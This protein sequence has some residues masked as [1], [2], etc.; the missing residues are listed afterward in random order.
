[1]FAN[2]L[3][4]EIYRISPPLI[5]ER[6]RE[7][8][9][10]VRITREREREGSETNF[11]LFF[12][13]GELASS[14]VDEYSCSYIIT[15]L[16]HCLANPPDSFIVGGKDSD[17]SWKR[18]QRRYYYYH[19]NKYPGIMRGAEMLASG[20]KRVRP[21]LSFFPPDH[22]RYPLKLCLRTRARNSVTIVYITWRK[23]EERFLRDEKL[24]FSK[25]NHVNRSMCKSALILLREIW[26]K[27]RRGT[28]SDKL[29]QRSIKQQ[30][31]KILV[32]RCNVF[33]DEYSKWKSV[34]SP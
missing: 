24:I 22:R 29:V 5:G 11:S 3:R 28:K 26:R 7:N 25:E 13:S 21:L 19:A 34:N 9:L 20:N 16:S 30:G 1:M 27:T 18:S 12:W 33:G 32:E 2:F 6:G 10:S 14:W 23:Y 4:L 15:F 8:L 17:N 31:L